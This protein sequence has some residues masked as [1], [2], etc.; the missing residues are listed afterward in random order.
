MEGLNVKELAFRLLT[1]HGRLSSGE[2]ARDAGVSRQTAHAVLAGLVGDGV[3]EAVG[4]GR[5]A[6][7][8]PAKLRS[9]RWDVDGLEEHRVWHDL[10]RDEAMETVQD[11]ALSVLEYAVTEMVNNVIDH[12][13]SGD[14][15]VR[16]GARDGDV[17]ISIEDTGI[18]A[19]ERVRAALQLESHLD[20][21]G[22]LSK[23]KL[24]T[25]P[26][27]HTGEGIFFTS[28]AVDRFVLV[29]N[30]V[31]WTIDNTIGDVAVGELDRGNGTVIGLTH[32]PTSGRTLESV[33]GEY[34]SGYD[35]DTSRIVVKLFEHG[36]SFVS[37][38]EARRVAVGLERFRVV[39]VDFDG[40]RRVGQGFVDELFRVW[41]S[42]HPGV[43][44]EPVNMNPAVE[45]MVRRGLDGDGG[46][47]G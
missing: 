31:E 20:A 14:L 10:L 2:L 33:F 35:F 12:S 16:I 47:I 3:A 43:R 13:G 37:R 23:G 28:K 5:G 19:L 18:G 32:D 4:A 1:L 25:D 6:H 40:I 24:T 9:Y 30:G 11:P 34:T 27:A 36:D 41:A 29:A 45:F 15:V 8:V 42:S 44:I 26:E 46:R 22:Q 7:Y 38:S 39:I 21:L 17:D